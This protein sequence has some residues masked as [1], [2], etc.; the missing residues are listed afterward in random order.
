VAARYEVVVAVRV[1]RNVE[2]ELRR[3]ANDDDRSLSGYLR[4][5]LVPI[6]TGP[7]ARAESETAQHTVAE[8][9]A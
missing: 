2:R 8:R 5:Q 9:D 7:A 4:R 6:T 1:P 3:R